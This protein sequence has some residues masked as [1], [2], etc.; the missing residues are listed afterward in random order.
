MG[1]ALSIQISALSWLLTTELNLDIHQVGIVWA[2][3][4]WPASSARSSS[5]SSATGSGSGADAGVRSS[6]W[7]ALLPR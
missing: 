4:P 5:G 3:G 1:F 6:F 2:A 7:A